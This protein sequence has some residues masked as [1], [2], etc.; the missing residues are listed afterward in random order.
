MKRN[1]KNMT[2]E[3]ADSATSCQ[4]DSPSLIKISAMVIA[5][6]VITALVMSGPTLLGSFFTSIEEK[7]MVVIEH[8]LFSTT[9]VRSEQGTI[10]TGFATVTRYQKAEVHQ[11]EAK[12]RFSDGLPVV[13]HGSVEFTL[14]EDEEQIKRLHEKHWGMREDFVLMN[15]EVPIA[16]AV[17]EVT[18][19]MS[20]CEFQTKG[21]SSDVRI[22][23]RNRLQ[24][25]HNLKRSGI[26]V[27]PV[28]IHSAEYP[29]T[30]A[31][32]L[33]FECWRE[34]EGANTS[35]RKQH[36]MYQMMKALEES[37]RWNG[38]IPN[39]DQISI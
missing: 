15:Y 21:A 27:G 5:G 4:G 33:S 6:L 13:I 1:P 9:S 7:E 10:L 30:T 22:A 36:L 31:A 39:P 37:S 35:V 25:L 29:S 8:P 12:A 20:S 34:N 32:N 14:P 26:Q 28:L 3:Q 24:E 23:L 16:R 19:E 11:F 17:P 18:Y 38:R 2:A